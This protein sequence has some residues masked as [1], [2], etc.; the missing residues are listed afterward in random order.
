MISDPTESEIQAAI[1]LYLRDRGIL[2]TRVP[3]GQ[4][5]FGSRSRHSAGLPDIIGVLPGGRFLGIEVKR[6]KARPR[7][8]EA[9]QAE[10]I[11]RAR[12]RGGLVIIATSVEDVERGLA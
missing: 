4:G 2:A 11:R 10:W 8:N 1:M 12:D 9:K 7:A 5:R 6:P 3:M